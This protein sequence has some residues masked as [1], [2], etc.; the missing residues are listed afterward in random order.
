MH[1]LCVCIHA[2]NGNSLTGSLYIANT[3]YSKIF[4]GIIFVDDSLGSVEVHL[5]SLHNVPCSTK[6]WL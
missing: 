3:V 1:A 4:K 2:S 6:L 5:S